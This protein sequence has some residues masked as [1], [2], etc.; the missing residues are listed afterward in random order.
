MAHASF[1]HQEGANA[2]TI[3]DATIACRKSLKQCT[4]IEALKQHSWAENR[5]ADF[6][7]WDSGL[8][9]CSSGQ[10]SLENRLILKPQLRSA[11]LSLLLLYQQSVNFCIELGNIFASIRA[12]PQ[13]FADTAQVYY[14]MS[15]V[16]STIIV[17]L[18]ATL[19]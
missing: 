2:T 8:A 4:E 19:V 9:A 14:T 17:K 15:G 5:L 18:P 6:N 7:I 16:N 10:A 1:S 13:V 3:A 12:F 11:V